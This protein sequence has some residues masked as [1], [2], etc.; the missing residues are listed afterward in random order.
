MDTPSPKHSEDR[1]RFVEPSLR[2]SP[3]HPSRRRVYI[4]ITLLVLG[5]VAI[6]VGGAGVRGQMLLVVG[7]AL[8]VAS[9]FTFA[10]FGFG[11]QRHKRDDDI[12]RLHGT[13]K[14]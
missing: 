14:A 8:V 5:F 11:P 6:F 9:L 4:G 7:F 12:R 10:A 3:E 1:T 13:N 2:P